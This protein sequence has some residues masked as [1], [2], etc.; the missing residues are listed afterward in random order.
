MCHILRLDKD[1]TATLVV[2]VR[3]TRIERV[4]LFLF[5]R[6]MVATTYLFPRGHPGTSLRLLERLRQTT[7][8]EQQFVLL[9]GSWQKLELT[10]HIL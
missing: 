5:M 8:V 7:I 2:E 4:S 9:S 3:R 10:A 1:R 6:A